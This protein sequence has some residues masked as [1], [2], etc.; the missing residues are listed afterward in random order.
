[1]R[2]I[3]EIDTEIAELEKEKKAI[4]EANRYSDLAALRDK[5]KGKWI[6]FYAH[7]STMLPEASTRIPGQYTIIHVTDVA[8]TVTWK[9]TVKVDLELVI[10][11]IDAEN[12]CFA[13]HPHSVPVDYGVGQYEFD[14]GFAEVIPGCIVENLL[15]ENELN[16]KGMLYDAEQFVHRIMETGDGNA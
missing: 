8:D 3:D 4:R 13:V 7:T 6:I 10:T 16:L 11:E 5:F 9:H 14:H 1:M 12:R 2:T 15:H